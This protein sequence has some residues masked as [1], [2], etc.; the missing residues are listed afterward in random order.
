MMVLKW[1]SSLMLTRVSDVDLKVTNSTSRLRWRLVNQTL[2]FDLQKVQ[3]SRQDWDQEELL[4]A[5]WIRSRSM[6]ETYRVQHAMGDTGHTPGIGTAGWDQSQLHHPM[7]TSPSIV[8]HLPS[9]LA[10]R[11][12]EDTCPTRGTIGAGLDFLGD[13]V[14]LELAGSWRRLRTCSFT[15][16]S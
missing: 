6:T 3:D 2:D 8:Q 5:W 7:R 4:M 13:L 9:I 10:Q 1:P 14:E 16:S 11:A 12:G 15:R